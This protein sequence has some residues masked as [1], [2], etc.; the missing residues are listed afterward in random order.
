MFQTLLDK[1]SAHPGL[2]GFLRRVVED[3]FDAEKDVIRRN[4]I[5]GMIAGS[6]NFSILAAVPANFRSVSARVVYRRRYC[7]ALHP[8]RRPPSP[9]TLRGDERRRA[10]LCF[11]QF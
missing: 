4:L 10:W 11:G 3:G 2:W 8:L 7:P 6:G 5:P 1:L 9:W